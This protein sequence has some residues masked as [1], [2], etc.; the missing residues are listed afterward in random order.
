[1]AT[2]MNP[3]T[4][5]ELARLEGLHAE[6]AA[7]ITAR[8]KTYSKLPQDVRIDELS[9]AHGAVVSAAM[10]YADNCG[11]AF[12][13]LLATIRAERERADKAEA[14]NAVLQEECD[15][16]DAELAGFEED[17][18]KANARAEAAEAENARLRDALVSI[19]EYWNGSYTEG[20]MSNALDVITYRARQALGGSNE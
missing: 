20:A 11:E 7:A 15:C 2:E 9:K 8:E 1:M 13:A 12:P 19:E 6:Y 18:A 10:E 4:E 17:L 14:D 5:E 16:H 3:L